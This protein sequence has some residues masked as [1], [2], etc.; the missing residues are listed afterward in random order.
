MLI[1]F[2]MAADKPDWI[3]WVGV[4]ADASTLIALI[5]AAWALYLHKKSIK[6]QNKLQYAETAAKLKSKLTTLHQ[7]LA[8]IENTGRHLASLS[9]YEKFFSQEMPS[10]NLHEVRD[11]AEIL[12]N[13]GKKIK[14][15]EVAEYISRYISSLQEI[16]YVIN[17]NKYFPG[18]FNRS[19]KS[20]RITCHHLL[21]EEIRKTYEGD[22]T[23]LTLEEALQAAIEK[24]YR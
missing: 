22:Y 14:C 11:D 7:H 15:T 17:A 6:G 9:D 2:D 16:Q 13:I 23:L 24:A 20:M 1:T 4:A 21:A 10:L 8:P 19:F 12:K 18:V 3:D 5:V